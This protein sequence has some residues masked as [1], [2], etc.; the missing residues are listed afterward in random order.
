MAGSSLKCSL[1]C[2]FKLLTFVIF[3]EHWS[4][5]DLWALVLLCLSSFSHSWAIKQETR[6]N[7]FNQI[8]LE[9]CALSGCQFQI[10]PFALNMQTNRKPNYVIIC[11]S[12]WSLICTSVSNLKP[13]HVCLGEHTSRPNCSKQ[14]PPH[15]YF[16]PTQSQPVLALSVSFNCSHHNPRVL[17]FHLF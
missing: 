4:V 16:L 9:I 13:P 1:I 3:Q 7:V 8:I 2:L 11:L 12:L 5:C 14:P 6:D 10:K 17:W 15:L